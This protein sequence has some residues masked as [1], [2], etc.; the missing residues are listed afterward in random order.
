MAL[1]GNKD[2]VYSLGTIA[3]DLATGIGTGAVGVVTWTSAGIK[4]GDVISVGTGGTFGQAVIS[5]FTSTT[6][7]VVNTAGFISGFVTTPLAYNIS[8]QPIYTLGDYSYHNDNDADATFKNFNVTGTATTTAGI[9]T[10]VIPVVV[11]SL[12][13]IVGDAIVNGGSN[14]PISTI[15]AT[16]VSLASTISVGIDTGDTI[17]FRRKT[18][19]YFKDVFGVD[20][21]EVGVAA[22]TTVAEKSAAYAVAHS[23]WVGVQTY[24]DCHGKLR[25]K[26]E[27]LVASGVLTTTDAA[28]D[29]RFPDS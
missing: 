20:A 12:D 5:G 28:D 25:V 29:A 13:V 19:G 8:E 18:G 27:V 7:S 4:T 10:D 1:W 11:G 22:G 17:A 2:S 9:G 21:I 23:G 14:L 26:S 16:T 6:I 24:I 15:G 3:V